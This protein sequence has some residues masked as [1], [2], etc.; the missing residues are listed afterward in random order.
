M[1][2]LAE[3]NCIAHNVPQLQ[4]GSDFNHRTSHEELHF[5][6]TLSSNTPIP[7]LPLERLRKRGYEAMLN[8]YGKIAPH[9]NEPLYRCTG[10]KFPVDIF[11]EGEECLTS[12][13][14]ARASP[15][16][17][18]LAGRGSQLVAEHIS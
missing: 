7:N 13:C 9:L 6:Y 3:F 2:I 15:C 4:P 11:D 10:L 14:R 18:L 5:K 12:N 16:Q 1:S 8:Y 17:C